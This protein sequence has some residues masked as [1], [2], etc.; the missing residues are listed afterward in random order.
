[1]IYAHMKAMCTIVA[2]PKSGTV[3]SRTVQQLEKVLD[4][5]VMN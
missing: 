5:N 2:P 4:N 3:P 1:M